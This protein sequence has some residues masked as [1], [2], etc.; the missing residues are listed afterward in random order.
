MFK[1]FSQGFQRLSNHVKVIV[2]SDKL[3]PKFT[4]E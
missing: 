3:S 4:S 2:Y 1:I